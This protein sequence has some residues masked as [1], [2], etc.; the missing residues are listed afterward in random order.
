MI[1]TVLL[2]PPPNK[3]TNGFCLSQSKYFNNDIS[4]K[5]NS[6]IILY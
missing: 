3:D 2:E 1:S 4:E 5:K 6:M